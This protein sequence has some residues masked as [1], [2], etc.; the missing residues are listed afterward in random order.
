MSPSLDELLAAARDAGLKIMVDG[1]RLVIRGPKSAEALA[2]HLLDRKA[3]MMAALRAPAPP[4]EIDAPDPSPA[5]EPD[6]PP[7]SRLYYQDNRG[8]PT[9]ARRAFLWC[10][11]GG[12]RWYYAARHPAPA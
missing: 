5:S 1:D 7:G 9:D 10:W 2:R 6:V 12:P 8:R 11:A 4:P 3:E